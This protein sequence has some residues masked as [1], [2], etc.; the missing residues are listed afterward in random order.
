MKKKCI[1]AETKIPIKASNESDDDMTIDK[2]EPIHC[3]TKTTKQKTETTLNHR[4]MKI[5]SI[6]IKINKDWIGD[7][8]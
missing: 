1:L 4:E 8:S 2:Q 3:T 5:L 7:Q 6:E